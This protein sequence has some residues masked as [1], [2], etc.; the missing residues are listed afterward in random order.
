MPGAGGATPRRAA[1]LAVKALPKLA[2]SGAADAESKRNMLVDGGGGPSR[3][4]DL[5][6]GDMPR[7]KR[8]SA[9]VDAPGLATPDAGGDAS[10]RARDRDAKGGPRCAEPSA[11]GG[12]STRL[13][14][15]SVGGGPR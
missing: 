3:P 4:E 12:G 14:L 6:E 1:L 9:T 2:G 8:S 15:R 11:A 10:C 5:G 7:W 13:G